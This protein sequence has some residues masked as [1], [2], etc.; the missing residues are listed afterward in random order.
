M[1]SK[2]KT[3][4]RRIVSFW[5]QRSKSRTVSARWRGYLW[6][7]ALLVPGLFFLS[8]LCVGCN[9]VERYRILTF[10]F[11]GVPP[12]DRAFLPAPAAFEDGSDNGTSD[13][14]GTT[15]A[16][17][18]QER[19][20]DH[21]SRDC[22]K[23]HFSRGGNRELVEPIPGLCYS[24]H[25]NYETKGE[26]VHGPV[27]V[28]ECKFCHE[29]HQSQYIHLQKAAQPELCYRCHNRQQMHTIA[30]HEQ[31][32]DAVCTECH[33][34]HVSVE[35]KLLKPGWRSAGDPNSIDNVE[36]AIEDPNGVK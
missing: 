14:G 13:G 6:L 3:V 31:M 12:V 9:D 19:G 11:E 16:R 27:A 18:A 35:P 1:E 28:G 15:R 8:F 22:T 2:E 29:G 4:V 32:Q 25:D 30:D 34:V 26:Y 17:S 5:I 10:F 24:C 36:T 20:S 33:E 21:P 23:C 7:F